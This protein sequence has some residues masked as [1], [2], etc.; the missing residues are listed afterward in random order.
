M[1]SGIYT[2]KSKAKELQLA[3]EGKAVGFIAVF[4]SHEKR[5]WP[6]PEMSIVFC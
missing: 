5:M 2:R 3:L 1:L 6:Q 4:S